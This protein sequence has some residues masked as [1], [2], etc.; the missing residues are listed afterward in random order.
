[1]YTTEQVEQT[2]G[3]PAL[4]VIP[5]SQ[6]LSRGE[7]LGRRRPGRQDVT[8]A[9]G[10]SIELLPHRDP[11]SPVAEAYRSFRT[12]LLL[13]RAG[14]L[15]SVVVTSCLPGEGKTS[16]AVNLAIV[17]TQLGK[18][19]LLVDADLHRPRLHEVLRVSNK[20]GLVSILAE[21]VEPSLAIMKTGVTGVFLV[22]AGPT[23]PNPSG[24][25][26]SEGM[27]K[28]LELAQM[29]FDYVIVDTPPVFPVSDVLVFAQQTDGV[30]LCVEAGKTPREE[31]IRARDRI[32]RSRALALG[33]LLNNLDLSKAGYPYAADYRFTYYGEKPAAQDRPAEPALPAEEVARVQLS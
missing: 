7:V 2:I 12:A 10:G 17:L 24:L 22:P 18:R 20:I 33:V 5:A 4:G 9:D 1:L 25:L 8:P 23:S 6:Q 11:R 14:G 3:L 13:S 26:S 15:R 29:N 28:F 32:Q 30:V 31:V 21:G 16:T 27:T 19:V